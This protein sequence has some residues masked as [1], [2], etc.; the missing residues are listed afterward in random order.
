MSPGNRVWSTFGGQCPEDWC[1]RC[2]DCNDLFLLKSDLLILSLEGGS[3]EDLV[4]RM[5][6]EEIED[7]TGGLLRFSALR[8]ASGR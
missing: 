8:E 5:N 2:K 1:V 4:I 7:S 6:P 3:L